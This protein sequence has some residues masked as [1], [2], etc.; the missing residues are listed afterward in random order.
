MKL[1][2]QEPCSKLVGEVKVGEVAAGGCGRLP[3]ILWGG[4]VAT[5]HANGGLA[6]KPGTI[7]ARHG[8]D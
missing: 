3:F 4:D 6:T 5:F 1:R 8:L 7:F 2:A